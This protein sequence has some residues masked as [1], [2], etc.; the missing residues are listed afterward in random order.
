MQTI[1]IRD[2]QQQTDQ[3]LCRVREE[4]ETF[5]VTD[6]GEVVARIVPAQEPPEA[7]PSLDEFL[8]RW[9]RLAQD[10]GAHWPE[11]VSAVDAVREQRREL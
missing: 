2:L 3:V 9:N 4:G 6:Q 5:E 11:G 10:I 7:R 1:G 8:A